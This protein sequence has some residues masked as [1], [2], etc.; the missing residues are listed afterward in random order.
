M[1]NKNYLLYILFQVTFYS[2]PAQNFRPEPIGLS[3]YDNNWT[4][5]KKENAF[6]LT[7]YNSID[8]TT[9]QWKYYFFAGP[10]IAIET[11]KEKEAITPH[12][13]FSW[14]DNNGYVDSSGYSIQG[15]KHGDW[16]YYTDTLSIWQIDTYDNG[17]LLSSQ[18]SLQLKEERR[19]ND[20]IGYLP[21]DK[22]AA[23]TGDTKG[24]ARY[25]ERNF[26]Y[27]ERASSLKKEGTVRVFFMVDAKGYLSDLRIYKSVELSLDNETIRL[28]E[29][30]PQWQPAMQLNKPVKAYRIQP[31]TFVL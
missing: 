26:R 22:E 17:K 9:H 21:G 14:Y 6:F 20:S 10:L 1:R 31:V 15:K 24:W 23:F 7:S 2:L 4:S 19:I 16:H 5:C 30:S 25:L 12:G 3:Y 18:D 27:P 11:Y 28:I 8:D 29:R 13:F